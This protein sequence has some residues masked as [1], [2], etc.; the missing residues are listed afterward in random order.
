VVHHAVP[1][2]TSVNGAYY[3]P[4][5]CNNVWH[6]LCSKQLLLLQCGLLLPQDKVI[7]HPI[8]ALLQD[9]LGHPGTS[10]IF[11]SSCS[12]RFLFVACVKGSLKGCRTAYADTINTAILVL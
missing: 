3:D 11:I 4:M 8:Q 10:S 6:T 12:V 2:W 5:L 7:P 9:W 1:P